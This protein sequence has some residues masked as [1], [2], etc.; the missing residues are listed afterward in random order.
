[1]PIKTLKGLYLKTCCQIM[2]GSGVGCQGMLD[3]ETSYETTFKYLAELA[4]HTELFDCS[5]STLWAL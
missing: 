4:E 1:M 2:M 5:L 3:T